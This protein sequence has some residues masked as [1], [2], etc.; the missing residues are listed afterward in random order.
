M[1]LCRCRSWLLTVCRTRI[2][3]FEGLEIPL[4]VIEFDENQEKIV[5]SVRDYFR[6]KDQT[7]Y[8]AYLE[9]HPIG[10]YTVDEET[11]DSDDEME[12]WGDAHEGGCSR[13]R[14]WRRK[15][16]FFPAFF[17][18][19]SVGRCPA[20]RFFLETWRVLAR[21]RQVSSSAHCNSPLM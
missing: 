1:A 3:A 13:R 15:L 18:L 8:E 11:A 17:T 4:K 16:V 19:R 6:D 12:S 20:L 7:E 21:Q 2:S 14:R 5:L 10:D 9:A